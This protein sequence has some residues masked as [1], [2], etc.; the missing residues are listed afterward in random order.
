[1]LTSIT[2]TKPLPHKKSIF[3]RA[4]HTQSC[5]LRIPVRNVSGKPSQTP[6]SKATRT[7]RVL[8]EGNPHRRIGRTRK[9]A[10][11]APASGR[12]RRRRHVSALPVTT[13]STS[14]S[15]EYG[16]HQRV[17]QPGRSGT[18]SGIRLRRIPLA[19]A[20]PQHTRPRGGSTGIPDSLDTKQVIT[21]GPAAVSRQYR[22]SSSVAAGI[23]TSP[24]RTLAIRSLLLKPIHSA[25]ALTSA[26][27]CRPGS[28][29][30]TLNCT[31]NA[32][33]R[34]YPPFFGEITRKMGAESYCDHIRAELRL[35]CHRE[36]RKPQNQPTTNGNGVP[37]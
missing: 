29:T 27:F 9:P 21:S 34:I 36:N 8:R 22:R 24:F 20:S 37:K 15:A 19:S 12:S 3:V 7:M 25:A 6:E 30:G 31:N 28:D 16:C 26:E 32:L 10:P 18:C 17:H 35:S 5:P 11:I 1:M 13:T 23:H 4:R 2:E 14:D 33:F